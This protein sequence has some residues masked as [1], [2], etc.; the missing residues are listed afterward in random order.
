[1]K[2]G[3]GMCMPLRILSGSI[4]FASTIVGFCIYYPEIFYFVEEA[5]VPDF[6]ESLANVQ[7]CGRAVLVAFLWVVNDVDYSVNLFR[8][9]VFLPEA[10]LMIRCYLLVLQCWLDPCYEEFLE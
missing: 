5:F 9:G 4:G 8:S 2:P 10:K 1:M 6:V 7:K 3:E